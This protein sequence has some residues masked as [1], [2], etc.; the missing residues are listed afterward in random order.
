[1]QSDQT[2]GHCAFLLQI[3]KT[4]CPPSL[5]GSPCRGLRKR[6]IFAQIVH[7]KSK[8]MIV[9]ML[10]A[11]AI[12]G[13][14][15]RRNRATFSLRQNYT[16]HQLFARANVAESVGFHCHGTP[17]TDYPQNG[18]PYAAWQSLILCGK[19]SYRRKKS[20]NL[21]TAPSY[22]PLPPWRLSSSPNS[23]ALFARGA[24]HRQ[25]CSVPAICIAAIT[26]PKE[27]IIAIRAPTERRV[28]VKVRHV[29][30]IRVYFL[31]GV[32]FRSK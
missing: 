4:I 16:R 18:C 10:S 25:Y 20:L 32:F 23:P 7:E 6:D 15:N 19:N 24:P 8:K 27:H 5:E 31:G 30:R 28:G 17:A 2:K 14:G 12:G 13:K 11:R 1:M 26:V 29:D 9:P 21:F 3:C 22:L